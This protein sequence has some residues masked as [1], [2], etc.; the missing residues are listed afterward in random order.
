MGAIT[1]RSTVPD[2]HAVPIWPLA[3]RARL[4]NAHGSERQAMN[5]SRIITGLD[6]ATAATPEPSAPYPVQ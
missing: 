1:C 3:L 6:S 2:E 5:R 4:L